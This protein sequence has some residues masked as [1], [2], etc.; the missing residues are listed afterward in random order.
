MSVSKVL[1]PV[2]QP[3][4]VT[5]K[6]NSHSAFPPRHSLQGL[7]WSCAWDCPPRPAQAQCPQETSPVRPA[8]PPPGPGAVPASEQSPGDTTTKGPERPCRLHLAPDLLREAAGDIRHTPGSHTHLGPFISLLNGPTPGDTEGWFFPMEQQGPRLGLGLGQRC[9]GGS[10]TPA[11][12]TWVKACAHTGR[13]GLA[14][15]SGPS[16]A[17][18]PRGQ[19]RLCARQ[20]RSRE[21]RRQAR[22][23][24]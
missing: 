9:S 19:A 14:F 7:M 4:Q 15:T 18:P 5:E 16:S 24:L 8:L 22:H 1:P 2:P 12:W 13:P 11:G 6:L 20:G 10:W 3:H 23:S 17:A 21:T